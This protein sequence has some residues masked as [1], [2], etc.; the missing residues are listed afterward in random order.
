MHYA[1]SRF[2]KQAALALFSDG[3]LVFGD[4][5]DHT[6][7][8]RPQLDRVLGKSSASKKF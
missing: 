8:A 6:T 5:T 4:H 3:Q 7:T 2:E 1:Q